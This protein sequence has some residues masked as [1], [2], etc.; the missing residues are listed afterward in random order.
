MNSPARLQLSRL[1]SLDM[2]SEFFQELSWAVGACIR[3]G[4]DEP[5]KLALRIIRSSRLFRVA[6]QREFALLGNLIERGPEFEDF[7]GLVRRVR[8]AVESY[9]Q[10]EPL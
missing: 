1:D 9:D 2:L 8:R 3:E 4:F 5:E 7:T 6:V 10:T